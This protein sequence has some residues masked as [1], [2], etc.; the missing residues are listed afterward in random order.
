VTGAHRCIPNRIFDVTVV[1]CCVLTEEVDSELTKFIFG[2][3][4]VDIDSEHETN[5]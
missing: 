4:N 3:R 2:A 5:D 1:A